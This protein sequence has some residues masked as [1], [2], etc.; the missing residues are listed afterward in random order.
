M[1]K[2]NPFKDIGKDEMINDP[3]D[4][5]EF[6]PNYI[7]FAIEGDNYNKFNKWNKK[8]QKKCKLKDKECAIGGRLTYI[9]N[10]TN[11]GTI[12]TVKCACGAELDLTSNNW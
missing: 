6:N 10:P 5:N 8:H 7:V 2:K 11:L 12:T 9:F 3:F 4:N 1:K